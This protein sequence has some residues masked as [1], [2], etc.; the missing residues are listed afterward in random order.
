MKM[1]AEIPERMIAPC[2]MNCMVCYVHLKKKKPCPG[3][4]QQ[5]DA[6]PEHCRKCKIKDCAF[7]K[8]V[9][10]CIECISFPCSVIKR[11]DKSY[12]K[13]YRVSLV[14]NAARIKAVGAKQ[15]LYEEKEKWTCPVCNGV[16]SLHDRVCSECGK[17]VC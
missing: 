8:G 12:Q 6:T 14:E 13:R 9:D 3:C 11:L 4:R 1:E 16:I 10:L 17:G 15:F 5:D 2:G 7:E